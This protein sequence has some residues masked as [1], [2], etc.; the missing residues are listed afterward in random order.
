MESADNGLLNEAGF[1]AFYKKYKEENEKLGGFL[2]EYDDNKIKQVYQAMNKID[3]SKDGLG[4]A[5]IV[6]ISMAIKEMM[7]QIKTN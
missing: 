1:I 6:A 2:P 4:P 3:T 7:K 5:E